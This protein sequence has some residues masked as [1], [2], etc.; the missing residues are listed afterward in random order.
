M[1]KP[2]MPTT[3]IR[4]ALI[5]ANRTC[6]ASTDYLQPTICHTQWSNLFKLL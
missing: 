4:H 3:K 5:C 1:V 2:V 6:S